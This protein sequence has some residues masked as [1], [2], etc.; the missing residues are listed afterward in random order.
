MS[1]Q[2]HASRDERADLAFVPV[3]VGEV[4]R[5]PGCELEVDGPGHRKILRDQLRAQPK[6]RHDGVEAQQRIEVRA[7]NTHTCISEDVAG[8]GPT[9]CAASVRS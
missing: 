7:A 6:R 2:A 3:R 5:R 8:C 4:D 9:G 1:S